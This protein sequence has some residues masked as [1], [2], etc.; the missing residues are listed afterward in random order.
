MHSAVI[1]MGPN[2]RRKWLMEKELERRMMMG[3]GG[4][5]S[6]GRHGN[7]VI[8]DRGTL[9]RKK[10]SSGDISQT[11]TNVKVRAMPPSL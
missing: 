1:Y 10:S 9:N 2:K 5:A 4:W 3:L 7:T 6:Y 11:S 8:T